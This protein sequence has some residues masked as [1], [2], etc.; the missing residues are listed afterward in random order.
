MIHYLFEL[1][2]RIGSLS[3]QLFRVKALQA[4]EGA[5]YVPPGETV[6]PFCLT[7]GVPVTNC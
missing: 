4:K 5:D 6:A 1:S 7:H 2:F 3:H